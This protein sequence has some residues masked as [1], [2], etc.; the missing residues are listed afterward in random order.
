MF[1]IREK[2]WDTT[3]LFKKGGL[4]PFVVI[5]AHPPALIPAPWFHDASHMWMKPPT[6]IPAMM[7]FQVNIIYGYIYIYIWIYINIYIYIYIWGVLNMMK[8]PK[9]PCRFHS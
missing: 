9:S 1:N 4:P 7:V 2:I 3:P 6:T 5:Q 8:I